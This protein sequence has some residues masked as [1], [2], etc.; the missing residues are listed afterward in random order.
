[1]GTSLTAIRRLL[2][3]IDPSRFGG[4]VIAVAG[5]VA[6]ASALGAVG[7]DSLWLAALGREIVE[8][9]GIPDGVPFAAAASSDWPN[10][11]V[12]AELA[13]HGFD[14]LGERGFLLAQV[15]AVGFGF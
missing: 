1:M 9:G 8:N 15:L 11:L 4:S 6:V 10:V 3:R 13:F 2:L 5:A 14:V 7:A 12:L